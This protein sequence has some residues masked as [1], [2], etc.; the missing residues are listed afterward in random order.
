M[1]VP[2]WTGTMIPSESEML[3]L[4]AVIVPPGSLVTV[5]MFVVPEH[6]AADELQ[7]A[8]AAGPS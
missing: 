4:P 6:D 8:A 5:W 7:R 2:L 1:P 3:L